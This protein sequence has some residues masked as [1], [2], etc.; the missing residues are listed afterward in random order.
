MGLDNPLHILFIVLILLLVFGAGGLPEIGRSL[1][2]GMREFKQSITGEDHQHGP[3]RR[4][5]PGRPQRSSPSRPPRRSR[6]RRHRRPRPAP[7]PEPSGGA[8]TTRPGARGACHRQRR[9][10][11]ALADRAAGLADRAAGALAAVKD[12]AGLD[13][14]ERRPGNAL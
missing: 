10:R 7:P 2:T 4:S 12:R 3:R 9:P 1:G 11:R 8:G 13:G 5:P 6:R 14:L